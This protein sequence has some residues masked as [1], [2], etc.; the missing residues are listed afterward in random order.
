[1]TALSEAILE[2]KHTTSINHHKLHFWLA[3]ALLGQ[4]QHM[5]RT[6]PDTSNSKFQIPEAPLLDS[7]CLQV[8]TYCISDLK[9]RIG[10]SIK[11]AEGFEEHNTGSYS[12][13]P[14]S[15]TTPL[16]RP[17]IPTLM[18]SRPRA[19]PAPQ[20]PNGGNPTGTGE[21][22]SGITSGDGR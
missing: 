2:G 9:P 22:P 20:I 12:S 1:M 8:A 16:R 11:H 14:A 3:S 13:R 21:W 4:H 7:R 18:K 15:C 5:A 17:G 6:V 10:T 19:A